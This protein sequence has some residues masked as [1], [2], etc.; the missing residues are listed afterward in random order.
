MA[1]CCQRTGRRHG[2]GYGQG[3]QQEVGV[4]G[5]ELPAPRAVPGA[6][7]SL[8]T[9]RA[10]AQAPARADGSATDAWDTHTQ[11][12]VTNHIHD[13]RKRLVQ[14][15]IPGHLLALVAFAVLLWYYG[16]P[17]DPVTIT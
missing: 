2:D 14:W 1:T 15:A 13:S 4:G 12:P 3:E 11:D 9:K 16:K 10:R 5:G 7:S 6:V 8:L 17:G